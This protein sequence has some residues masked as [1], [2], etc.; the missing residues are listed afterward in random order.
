MIKE[1]YVKGLFLA[2]LAGIF[3]GSMG[4]VAQYLLENC[5]F[6]AEDLVSLRLAGAGFLLLTFE[7]IVLR[8]HVLSVL[9]KER[10]WLSVTV[11]GIGLLGVQY[12]FFLSIRESYAATAA[13]MAMTIPL[14][15]TGWNALQERR[16]I[17]TR[18]FACLVLAL[19][20]IGLI[21]TG[22]DLSHADLNPAGVIWG[23]VP[24]VCGA[25]C[26]IQPKAVLRRLPVGVVAGWGMLTGGLL[27][28][29][30]CPPSAGT[31]SW[32]PMS[33]VFYFYIVAFGTVAAFCCYLASFRFI[34]VSAAA[35]LSSF[36]PLT[37]VLLGVVFMGLALSAAEAAGILCIL[38][39]TVL[40]TRHTERTH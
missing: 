27:M 4:S 18:E 37:A 22:G 13:L 17:T 33:L 31:D 9:F 26:N 40:L 19:A 10:N 23:L 11:Y 20:G 1:S 38:A 28:C 15:V 35:L 24:E 12:A 29:F 5:R 30:V 14:M 21:V 8:R 36:E 3:W 7:R 6:T 25:F 34:P 2:G 39:M 16:F 32:T